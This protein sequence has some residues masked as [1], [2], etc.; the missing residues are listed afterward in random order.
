MCSYASGGVPVSD[1]QYSAEN[2]QKYSTLNMI[3]L[4]CIYTIADEI[5]PWNKMYGR[6]KQ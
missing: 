6:S 5:T 2:T 3:I 1:L 4:S